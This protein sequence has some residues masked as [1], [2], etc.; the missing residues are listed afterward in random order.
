MSS[1]ASRPAGAP[2]AVSGSGVVSAIGVGVEA[3]ENAL[4]AGR[5]GVRA[6]IVDLPG[7]E[8]PAVP[9]AAAD[10][11]ATAVIAP[12]RLP[13]DRATAMAL[14]AADEA[15]R[16]AGIPAGAIDP[17]RLGIFWGS[18]MAGASTFETTCR[19]VYAERR[20]MRPTSVVTTM[21][22]APTAELALRF[23]ARGAALAYACACASSAVAIGEAMRA[24][25]AGWVDVAIAG[26]SE[27]LLTPGV[28]ASWQAMRVLAPVTVGDD[29][30]ARRA[31]RPFAADRAGFALGEAAAAFV[32]ESSEHV[33]ARG[34]APAWQL[35]GYATNCDGV[36][37]TNPDAAG[38]ARAMRAALAD[39]GVDPD[40]I[41]HVNAHGT[42]T[43]AGDGSEATA[44]ASVF[45][46][47]GV[48]VTATKAI[49]GHLLG[50]GGAVELLAA[51]CALM[52]R[53]LPPTAN[54]SAVDPAFAL[55]LVT[56][57]ARA[58]PGL[59]YAMS[60]S[61]AF[62]GTNAVLVASRAA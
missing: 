51:A 59:R 19:I 4:F 31:C 20:R 58:A 27:S 7:I 18:G 55:D 22:N 3:F 48:P 36:H 24:I 62:G 25:R 21:P 12:S 43:L 9:I 28:V 8:V 6:H 44:L 35:A 45:G 53:R 40:A 61:F 57:A 23:G 13:L 5:S 42:A 52:A 56:E 32:L 50:A 15:V 39:A 38:Q 11:D 34:A 46:P 54:T 37:I 29:A 2:V 26:G 30:A 17:E 47:G 33:R 16:R 60:N 14:V 49:H 1:A 41:G 10:F